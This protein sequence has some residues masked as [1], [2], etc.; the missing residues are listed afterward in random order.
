MARSEFDFRTDRDVQEHQ[1]IQTSSFDEKD[2]RG[3][4]SPTIFKEGY[5]C[6]CGEKHTEE[7]ENR[8]CSECD[9]QVKYYNGVGYIR[10]AV[11]FT[12]MTRHL[13]NL[14]IDI[15]NIADRNGN[16]IAYQGFNKRKDVIRN[17]YFVPIIDEDI[18][19]IIYNNGLGE[20]TG[21]KAKYAYEFR[22]D[23]K[24]KR[25]VIASEDFFV[26]SNTG[27]ISKQEYN[28]N[29][30]EKLYECLK[31]FD[32]NKDYDFLM[33]RLKNKHRILFDYYHKGMQLGGFDSSQVNI[34]DDFT[35]N[36]IINDY[37][38]KI[39]ECYNISFYYPKDDIESKERFLNALSRFQ[40][41]MQEFLMNEKLSINYTKEALTNLKEKGYQLTDLMRW[42]RPLISPQL[43]PINVYNSKDNINIQYRKL[44][45]T[46]QKFNTYLS[47]GK[48]DA[49]IEKKL[50]NIY[51]TQLKK[52]SDL[53]NAVLFDPEGLF[54]QNK[55]K[56][57]ID[58]TSR[59]TILL[60]K[61]LKGDQI[62]IPYDTAFLMGKNIVAKMLAR[63]SENLG[64]KYNITSEESELI[65]KLQT[66]E[67]IEKYIEE[68]KETTEIKSLVEDAVKRYIKIVAHRDPTKDV[69]SFA[70][71][72]YINIDYS[73]KSK[74]IAIPYSFC[75]I[76]NA[77]F[78][79][80]TMTLFYYDMT[81]KKE[82][83]V[84]KESLTDLYSIY[85]HI[86]T[87]SSHDLVID[88]FAHTSL[89]IEKLTGEPFTS[90]PY[91][92][93]INRFIDE[94][95]AE[96]EITS[97]EE[98][99][100]TRFLLFPS[101]LKPEVGSVIKA[102]EPLY[103]QI[104]LP[105]NLTETNWDEIEAMFD[106]KR[107]PYYQTAKVKYK[108]QEYDTTIGRI[109]LANRLSKVKEDVP[110]DLILSKQTTAKNFNNFMLH[111]EKIVTDRLLAKETPRENL[112]LE[113]GKDLLAVIDFFN[114][115]GAEMG[116]RLGI[117][118]E[119][120]VQL[121]PNAAK[122]DLLH[123]L[124]FDEIEEK[125]KNDPL[126]DYNYSIKSL[127]KFAIFQKLAQ[128]E[129]VYNIDNAGNTKIVNS[130]N[131]EFNKCLPNNFQGNKASNI[132][133]I[134]FIK[135]I[136][137]L[138][139]ANIKI[140]EHDCGTKVFITSRKETPIF[141]EGGFNKRL[142][143]QVLAAPIKY[144]ENDKE[145]IYPLGVGSVITQEIADKINALPISHVVIN[146][147]N[148]L[149][150]VNGKVAVNDIVA[151]GKVVVK[152][153]EAISALAIEEIKNDPSITS[154][155]H[156]DVLGCIADG[157]CS[158]CFGSKASESGNQLIKVGENAV[159]QS[160]MSAFAQ[161]MQSI[162]DKGK[163]SLVPA[164]DVLNEINGFFK[165]YNYEDQ[166]SISQNSNPYSLLRY[167]ITS[168]KSLMG[169]YR[170]ADLKERSNHLGV[171][172][173]A[174]LNLVNREGET[175]TYK[176]YIRAFNNGIYYKG[177]LGEQISLNSQYS[178]GGS[179]TDSVFQKTNYNEPIYYMLQGTNVQSKKEDK[180]QVKNEKVQE[181]T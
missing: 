37:L 48:R 143:N 47:H 172:L 140:T 65:L 111:Y 63:K 75:G 112:S 110:L 61:E 77:D 120:N 133:M 151:N 177:F 89:G 42:Y 95:G 158:C 170:Q 34:E 126:N 117:S 78:D 142:T 155:Q 145:K 149:D 122:N 175:L 74:L 119:D 29:S 134:A 71:P 169:Y 70:M 59:S 58:Q 164:S 2:E 131:N 12:N 62:T 39:Y 125:I 129:L 121:I 81:N 135:K 14:L 90:L 18:D 152:K 86:W 22:W 180:S 7:D 3:L 116:Q 96:V 66:K 113:I 16:M 20:F 179:F 176:D 87:T 144:K 69:S 162:L 153:G 97:G 50:L 27:K 5:F 28:L 1:I 178:K 23:D 159:T 168:E 165:S 73:M 13:R 51:A 54:V 4:F 102:G 148:W 31:Q 101:A 108:D 21:E 100:N 52:T 55:L 163:P 72:E 94:S 105:L 24:E 93:K 114:D 160:C 128:L 15:P 49:N 166:K 139:F 26:S 127:K 137:A 161:V 60:Q 79:G 19:N 46:T 99:G 10:L 106:S 92:I 138:F 32:L 33:E 154:I 25:I 141:K 171:M 82:R 156:R 8:R 157:Y 115:Y 104:E 174:T 11:P 30:G 150:Y 64:K 80:D 123:P 67:D 43:R 57:K 107:I 109:V 98:K 45:E 41:N 146:D 147:E 53:E 103:D 17:D 167:A 132:G 118:I 40:G 44:F 38:D 85:N 88:M 9:E 83:E 173:L 6:G 136:Y 68:N 35:T 36:K 181:R 76:T 84:V 56:Y 130:Y 91:D 124:T